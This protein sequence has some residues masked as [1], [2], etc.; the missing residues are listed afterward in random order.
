M[1]MLH[2]RLGV[3]RKFHRCCNDW[4]ERRTGGDS[5]LL[6]TSLS[7]WRLLN[8]WTGAVDPSRWAEPDR[9]LGDAGHLFRKLELLVTWRPG[10]VDLAG[11]WLRSL[12]GFPVSLSI[13]IVWELM[14]RKCV[15]GCDLVRFVYVYKAMTSFLQFYLSIWLMCFVFVWPLTFQLLTF[16]LD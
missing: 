16:M 7:P 5:A 8:F 3:G 10:S 2:S 14:G 4:A 1:D 9:G 11:A 13:C 12:A 15:W 6:N